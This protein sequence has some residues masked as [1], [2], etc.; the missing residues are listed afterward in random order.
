MPKLD[1]A[2]ASCKLTFFPSAAAG[3]GP[4]STPCS[5]IFLDKVSSLGIENREMF[6]DL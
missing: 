5:D 3:N 1:Q 4:S 6:L 2:A